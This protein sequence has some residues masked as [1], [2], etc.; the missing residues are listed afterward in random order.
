MTS[1]RVRHCPRGPYDWSDCQCGAPATRHVVAEHP[2]LE[3]R[4][5]AM[6]LPCATNAANR[7]E[8]IEHRPPPVKEPA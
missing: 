7:A 5:S 4:Y 3:T 2:T 8:E 6:C 1:W